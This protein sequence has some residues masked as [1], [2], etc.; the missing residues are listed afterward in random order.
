MTR[1]HENE[2]EKEAKKKY[3]RTESFVQIVNGMGWASI[4]EAL[5]VLRI[6]FVSSSFFMLFL[7][8]Q[9]ELKG[10]AYFHLFF[11]DNTDTDTYKHRAIRI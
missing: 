11:L 6:I 1:T 9:L 2:K 3:C 8:M 10:N 7:L 4:K 5:S